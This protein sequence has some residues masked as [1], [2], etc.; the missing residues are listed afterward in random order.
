MELLDREKLIKYQ[1]KYECNQDSNLSLLSKTNIRWIELLENEF[2]KRFLEL[3][4]FFN[5]QIDSSND[6]L[7]ENST[8][9]KSILNEI[10]SVFAQLA[11]KCLIVFD[12]NT[13]LEKDLDN[14]KKELKFIRSERNLLERKLL[15][16]QERKDELIN[17]NN[18]LNKQTINST[19]LS[20]RVMSLSNVSRSNSL[21]NIKCNY[22]QINELNYAD[23]E[24]RNLRDDNLSLKK[25]NLSLKSELFGCRLQLKYL[26]KELTGRIQQIQILSK[27][28]LSNQDR[29]RLLNQI[30]TEIHLSQS[31]TVIKACRDRE[32]L[33]FG[34]KPNSPEICDYHKKTGIGEIRRVR[35]EK[36]NT[37][38]LGISIT[39]GKLI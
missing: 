22:P 14:C 6:N 2:D 13:K 30:E 18:N 26:K 27:S 9:A 38:G 33:L 35:I 4:S 34:R 31:K 24:I 21:L 15:N 25:L 20:N 12:H 7:D 16:N 32:Q 23:E 19:R 17:L 10:S 29:S 36:S 28:D 5:Q 8:H 1:E 11:H 39:G 3:D 37:E